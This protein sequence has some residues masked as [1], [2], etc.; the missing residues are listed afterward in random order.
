MK[1]SQVIIIYG[2]NDIT[3]HDTP[4]D[5][6]LEIQRTKMVDHSEQITSFE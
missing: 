2:L 3:L 6:N 4:N 5:S 1:I